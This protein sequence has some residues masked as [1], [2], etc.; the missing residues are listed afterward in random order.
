MSKDDAGDVNAHTGGDF[1][2]STPVGDTK[3][4]GLDL[5]SCDAMICYGGVSVLGMPGDNPSEGGRTRLVAGLE[6]S[7]QLVRP[8]SWVARFIAELEKP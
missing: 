6:F 2:I 7:R 3:A 4:V 1:T 5:E 8:A